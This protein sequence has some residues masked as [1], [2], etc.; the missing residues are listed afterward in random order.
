MT[1]VRQK[2]SV[3]LP[4]ILQVCLEDESDQKKCWIL[5]ERLPGCQLGSAWPEMD[6]KARAET[7][8]QLR[9]HLEQLH[10]LHPPQAG[11]VGSISG[12]PV[13]DHRLSNMHTCGPFVSVAEFHD[14]LVAP[15]TQCPH[16]EQVAK[17][18]SQ[19]P[20]TYATRFSHAD[21]SGENILVDA[22]TGTVTGI[23][24]WEMAGFWPEWWEYRK[25]LFGA[26]S[27]PWWIEILNQV[28]KEYSREADLDM[29][30]E[31]Y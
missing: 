19:L 17:Y 25:A 6:D 11:L 20:D 12:G 10:Q 5:M 2:T 14:F 1:Y 16:P 3:P 7:I 27:R 30:V 15:V 28:M 8:R 4:A 31:M 22:S 26:R 24:D 13:Y 18:R 23:L 21:L 29:D 9:S